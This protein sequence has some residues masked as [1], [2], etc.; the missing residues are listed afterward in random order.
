MLRIPSLFLKL[1]AKVLLL[2][3]F[4]AGGLFL[5]VKY[6]VL[7]NID[8]WRPYIAQQL[9]STL[10][11]AVSL[12]EISADWSGLNPRLAMSDVTLTDKR[13]RKV[14]SL[15]HIQAEWSWRSLVTLTPQFSSIEARGVDVSLRRDR[16]ERFWLL[17]QSFD[18]DSPEQLDT[19][20][21]DQA[22]GWLATQREVV[23]R[24]S[25]LR[26]L[27]ETRTQTTLVFEDVTLV[28]QNR[29]TDHRF[30]LS[31]VPPVELGHSLDL[32]G[33]FKQF[34]STEDQ[35][36]S[37]QNSAGRLYAHVDRMSPAGWSAWIDTPPQLVSGEVSAKGWI[38][39]NGGKIDHYTS[40]MTSRNGRWALEDLGDDAYIQSEF[41]RLYL[42]GPWAG[43]QRVFP[44]VAKRGISGEA[45]AGQ[46]SA[47]PAEA[48][49]FGLELRGLALQATDMFEHALSF[50]EIQA[51]GNVQ[52]PTGSALRLEV[53]RV[54][55]SN[56]DVQASLAGNWQE[57]GPGPAGVI[58]VYGRF[59]RALIASI[60]NYLPNVV[61]PDA[62]EWMATGLLDG[63][64][65]DAHLT[66]KGDL[67]HF[68]FAQ[69]PSRGTFRVAGP[70]SGGVIDYL[71]AEGE[72]LGWPRITDMHGRVA[73][74]GADLR[75]VADRALMH[76]DSR[77]P[78]QLSNVTAHI[79]NI[80]DDSVLAIQGAT[81]G[82]AETY[83]ALMTH[84]PLG[85]LLDGAFDSATADGAWEVP[86]SLR[87][88]LLHSRDTT[89]QGAIRFLD[90]SLRLSP[91]LPP[92]TQA[93]GILNFTDTGVSSEG[94][95]ARFLGGPVSLSGGVGGAL[96]GLHMQGQMNASALTSFVGV[97]GMK[98]MRGAVP[99]KASIRRPDRQPLS[100]TINSDLAGLSL[101]LPP[102]LGK[103]AAQ[104]LPLRVDWRRHSDGKSMALEIALGKDV[105]ATLLHDQS[106]GTG[107]Y[108]YSAAL[109]VDQNPE[110]PQAGAS[111]DV[112]YPS[113]DVDLW[114]RVI[115]EFST[116]LPET[117]Q[118]KQLLLPELRQLRLQTEQ[119]R[120]LGLVFDELTFTARRPA[121]AQW[122]VDISS[123]QT[124][125]TLFWRE[126]HRRVAGRVDARFDRLALGSEKQ[127][128]AK[129]NE[130]DEPSYHISDD[131]DIPGV[132][133]YVKNL[134][135][136]G[137]DAGELS[138]VGVNQARGRLWQLEQ[139]KLTG[140][141]AI[142]TGSGT[143]R[144]SG[145]D[146]GLALDAEAK[147]SDLGKYLEYADF[148]E[149]MKGGSGKAVG[150]FE[151]RNMPWDVSKA[152]LN[153]KVE[154]DLE[155]GRFSSVDS[156]SSRLLELLSLQSLHRLARMDVNPAGLIKE[157]FP[158]DRLRGTLLL[159]DGIMN[160]DDYRVVG[161]V[162]TIVIAGD[163][164]LISERLNLEAVV[165]PNLDVSGAAIAAGIAINPIVGIGAF[166]TQWLLQAPLAKAMTARYHIDGDWD[167]PKIS[168][169]I[170]PPEG[171]AAKKE[172]P[173]PVSP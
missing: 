137:R 159:N 171:Q 146:R 42:A 84:S 68:P 73:L 135:L 169:A 33:E 94:M 72:S 9:S 46:A 37:L 141:G 58:D 74:N 150:R 57:G 54:N 55:L 129:G 120:A 44:S 85:G 48:I 34:A 66:L 87:I 106:K 51:K 155:K 98:R 103:L 158:Y 6:W 64:I 140:P 69:E 11:V 21:H 67:A 31:A 50:D 65:N 153:G 56:P 20:A 35:A 130:R 17:G 111:V 7:P 114:D 105:N 139:L 38:A 61:S 152:D 128:A 1:L 167:D 168:D 63:R 109:G 5:G 70:F 164:N 102:P 36:F 117:K 154:I 165:V 92:F 160:T 59:P 49:E 113:V 22:L 43:F 124:A 52:N 77:L 71:P 91:D 118:Q 121:I 97:Q 82:K 39:L 126:A 99:Y 157:G 3:Y 143:W 24:D 116:P 14:L 81:S 110:L 75:L 108:F 131:L 90:N 132:N 107:P 93:S 13:Q 134:R 144:L 26:W 89:V 23:L 95:K 96:K 142:L 119:A 136:Y 173:R 149:I 53:E 163:I 16:S 27:D 41:L 83:L 47:S 2:V 133:L 86:L 32:R 104:T 29:G 122:R 125:G 28:L 100:F 8:Q 145:K 80:E 123:S 166:L 112:R 172:T 15:P 45:S 19:G 12:G 156:R 79:P 151:W 62:R 88:P 101:D 78:I 10:N 162:G 170:V 161:P 18:A 127:L 4:G 138:V 76:P 25:T 60:D 40:D 30:S 115:T 148:G 147:F